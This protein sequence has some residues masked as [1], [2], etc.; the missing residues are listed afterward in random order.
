MSIQTTVT[1]A[2]SQAIVA[3]A[4]ALEAAEARPAVIQNLTPGQASKL[5]AMLTRLQNGS[6]LV[7]E[8]QGLV[9]LMYVAQPAGRLE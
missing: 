6:K 8:R 2:E 5:A 3:R 1:L 7:I 9:L 4:R